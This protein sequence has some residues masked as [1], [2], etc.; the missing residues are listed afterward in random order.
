MDVL[1]SYDE[2]MKEQTPVGYNVVKI[3]YKNHIIPDKT[4]D[5]YTTVSNYAYAKYKELVKTTL[6]MIESYYQGKSLDESYNYSIVIIE[7]RSKNIVGGDKIIKHIVFL[8]SE[9]NGISIIIDKNSQDPEN[10][11]IFNEMK[12]KYKRLD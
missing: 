2:M 8:F 7:L 5:K 1:L 12:E 10:E 11:K 3:V 4:Y 9:N 6:D